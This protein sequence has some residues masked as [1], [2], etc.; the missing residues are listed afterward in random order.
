M[1]V[2]E[3]PGLLQRASLAWW[4]AHHADAARSLEAEPRSLRHGRAPACWPLT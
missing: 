4:R 1:I 2:A 3:K